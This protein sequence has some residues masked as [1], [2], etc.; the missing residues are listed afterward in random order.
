MSLFKFSVIVTLLCGF[1]LDCFAWNL[2]RIV[3]PSP[4]RRSSEMK[5]L[6]PSISVNTNSKSLNHLVS[7]YINQETTLPIETAY[8][9]RL[10][11]I[12]SSFL[13]QTSSF[14]TWKTLKSKA[15]T[16]TSISA[17]SLGDCKN[18]NCSSVITTIVSELVLNLTKTKSLA[19]RTKTN[20]NCKT[21]NGCYRYGARWLNFYI[22]VS[23]TIF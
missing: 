13:T 11:T 10:A 2:T 16:S 21:K 12:T 7:G 1:I 18:G 14:S 20:S 8:Y 15:K 6:T 19:N 17:F 9:S 3:L 22:E 23:M 5:H 4:S